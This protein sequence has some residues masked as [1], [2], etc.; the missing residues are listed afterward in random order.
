MDILTCLG[1]TFFP[2]RLEFWTDKCCLVVL[3]K[4]LYVFVTISFMETN[5]G[6]Q[7]AVQND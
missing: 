3:R 6:S 4:T 2:S 5:E 7:N 1:V